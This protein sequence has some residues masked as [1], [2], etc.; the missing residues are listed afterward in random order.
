MG[1]QRG[2]LWP[3]GQAHGRTLGGGW[4]PPLGR[5]CPDRVRTHRLGGYLELGMSGR[6]DG[7]EVRHV[8]RPASHCRVSAGG[9]GRRR[10]CPGG[11]P[12]AAPW[13]KRAASWTAGMSGTPRAEVLEVPIR[14][15]RVGCAGRR[16]A[17]AR[18]PTSATNRATDDCGRLGGSVGIGSGSRASAVAGRGL[19]SVGGSP[20]AAG[21]SLGTCCSDRAS[22]KNSEDIPLAHQNSTPCPFTR[23]C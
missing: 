8:C 12:A 22:I 18:R 6:P 19:C 1:G 5:R 11:C 10:R 9:T 3:A 16:A 20:L 14:R 23:P 7:R 2:W 17:P 13:R 15:S 21:E 4:C